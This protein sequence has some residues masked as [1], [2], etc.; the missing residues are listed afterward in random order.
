MVIIGKCFSFYF[1]VL[2]MNK[3]ILHNVLFI[4][5]AIVS[6]GCSTTEHSGYNCENGK[7][8]ASFDNPQYLTLVDC[9]GDC[10]D[11]NNQGN[12]GNNTSNSSGYNCIDGTCVSVS[13]NAQY[14]TLSECQSLCITSVMSCLK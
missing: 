5:I 6:Y 7:C 10:G 1:N 12:T 9:Q 2:N 8:I 3:L 13:Y 14:K 11:N 4:V